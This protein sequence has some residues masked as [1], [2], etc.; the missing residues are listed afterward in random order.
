MRSHIGKWQ[1][2][3]GHRVEFD[4]FEERYVPRNEIEPINR[5]IGRG[6]EIEQMRPHAKMM[7]MRV[8]R[9][10]AFLVVMTG[11]ITMFVR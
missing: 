9:S 10:I 3:T 6:V 4:D 8:I 2:S 7:L 5:G 11:F 1:R